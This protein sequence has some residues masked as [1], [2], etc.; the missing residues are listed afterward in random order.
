MPENKV[1]VDW[2]IGLQYPKLAR[3]I[4]FTTISTAILRFSCPSN[5]RLLI[6]RV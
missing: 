2:M 4:P 3:I 6:L 1:A 5:R